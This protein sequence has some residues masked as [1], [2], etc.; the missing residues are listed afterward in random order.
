MKRSLI[1]G[2]VVL[3]LLLSF[4]WFAKWR[5]PPGLTGGSPIQVRGGSIHGFARNA[6]TQCVADKDIFC[7][8]VS[9]NDRSILYSKNFDSQIPQPG[10][11]EWTIRVTNQNGNGVLLCSNVNCDA[12]TPVPGNQYIYIEL[13]DKQYS[14]WLPASPPSDRFFHDGSNG[15]QPD[16]SGAH[17]GEGPCDKI[18]DAKVF[19]GGLANATKTLHCNDPSN[20]DPSNPCEIA[21]GKPR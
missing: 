5:W 4:A 9:S 2:A 3:A 16:G 15:C 7:A 18:L 21:V 20:N 14:S 12:V 10:K 11:V 8:S 13:T 6:W 19:V 17:P 1:G